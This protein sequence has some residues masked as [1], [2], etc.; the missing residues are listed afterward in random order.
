MLL[1][2]LL[3]PIESEKIW[4]VLY[5]ALDENSFDLWSKNSEQIINHINVSLRSFLAY[6]S[7]LESSLNCALNIILKLLN[8]CKICIIIDEPLEILRKSEASSNLENM[9]KRCA[10]ESKEKISFFTL[11][12][13]FL[14]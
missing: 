9:S 13:N 3:I 12:D 8:F 6:N 7:Y 4:R 11:Y 14:Y 5:S 1:P 2:H 10:E